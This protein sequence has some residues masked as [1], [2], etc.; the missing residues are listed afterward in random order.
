MTL[1]KVVFVRFGRAVAVAALA[2]LVGFSVLQLQ[3]SAASLSPQVG[4]GGT[5]SSTQACQGE[6]GCYFYPDGTARCI[7]AL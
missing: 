5:C 3:A 1:K 2:A 7:D 6:C 4:C